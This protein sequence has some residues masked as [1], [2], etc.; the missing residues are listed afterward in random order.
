MEKLLDDLAIKET[1]EIDV[2]GILS[3]FLRQ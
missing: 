1:L 3:T 2:A